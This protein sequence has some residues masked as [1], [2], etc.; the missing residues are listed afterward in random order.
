M[1]ILMSYTLVEVEGRVGSGIFGFVETSMI[2]K[3]SER[4]KIEFNGV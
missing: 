3:L 1:R 2:G 4:M